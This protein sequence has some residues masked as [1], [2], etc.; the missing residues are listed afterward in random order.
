MAL[1]IVIEV[2]QGVMGVG[3]QADVMDAVADGA[4]LGVALIAALAMTRG[5]QRGRIE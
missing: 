3:R 1:G 5:D 2:L 4:G